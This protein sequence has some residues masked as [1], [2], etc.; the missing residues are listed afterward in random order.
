MI[1]FYWPVILKNFS[2]EF[3]VGD[4]NGSWKRIPQSADIMNGKKILAKSLLCLTLLCAAMT[5][6]ASPELKHLQIAYPQTIQDVSSDCITWKDGTRMQVRGRFALFDWFS[7]KLGHYDKSIGSISKLDLEHDT[8]EPFFRKMYGGTASEVRKKLVTIYW[9]PSV[10]GKRYPLKVTTVNG[11][12]K[13]LQRIS[14]QLE[15]LPRTYLKFLQNPAGSFYWR[16]VAGQS[17]L[18]AHSFGIAIDINSSYSNYWLWDWQRLHK[19][20]S[21]L[22]H[23]NRVPMQIVEIFEKEGF[24][25]GGR[26]DFYDTMHFEYRPELFL[27]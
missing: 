19:P 5:A 25:W 17:Y 22:N 1:P 7:S 18:S 13:K 8:Y 20:I 16:N 12:D 21:Q 6:A 3:F 11:I 2:G 23:H 14:A 9:M 24:Y 10:F 4:Y 15:K 26:W 27:A